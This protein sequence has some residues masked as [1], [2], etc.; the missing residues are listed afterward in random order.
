M[1]ICDQNPSA[2]HQPPNNLFQFPHKPLCGLTGS[3]KTKAMERPP[4]NPPQMI[5]FASEFV[6]CTIRGNS[7]LGRNTTIILDNNTINIVIREIIR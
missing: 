4:L 3:D 5:I 2:K 1:I 6:I 7:N